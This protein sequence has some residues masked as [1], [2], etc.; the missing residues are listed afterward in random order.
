MAPLQAE[1]LSVRTSTGCR[2][3]GERDVAVLDFDHVNEKRECISDLV[4]AGASVE[5]LREEL[6][7]CEVVCANCHRR[8]T[9]SRAEWRRLSMGERDRDSL[10]VRQLRNVRFV[11]GVLAT[12]VCADCGCADP[13]LLEF[14]HLRDKRESVMVLAWGEYGLDTLRQEMEKCEIRCCNCHRRV[15]AKRAAGA[16]AR[17]A[18]ARSSPP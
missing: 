5:R 1:V 10:R 11:Y 6:A 3:C 12:N 16:M 4:R 14:D 18:A 13:L 15:T 2:D 7:H 17:Y 9:A 8:R